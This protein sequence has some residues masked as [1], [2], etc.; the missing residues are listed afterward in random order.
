MK[1]RFPA[2]AF[3]AIAAICFAF[4]QPVRAQWTSVSEVIQFEVM[5]GWR[6]ADGV[7]VAALRVRLQP[8]WKTYW[9]SAGSVG[10]APQMDWRGSRNLR[11]VTPAWPTPKVFGT[12]GALSIGYDRDFILPLLIPAQGSGPIGL[13]GQLSIGVCADICL[14]AQVEISADLPAAGAPDLTIEAALADRPRRVN[15]TA[16]CNLRPIDNGFA[17]TSQIDLPSQGRNEAVV[18]E[19]PN[20][21]VWVTD[22]VVSRRG[23]ELR[24]TSELIAAGGGGFALDR[25]Q[26][27]ITVIG[28]GGAVEIEGCTG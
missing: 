8:G 17:M 24:A 2:W 23:S 7:H 14:P 16:R 28:T 26:V 20:A 18:F 10:I 21:S 3:L 1:I 5:P 25:S 22:A 11:S 4:P 6:R 12:E 27:R 13:R 19:V 9:R 15:A